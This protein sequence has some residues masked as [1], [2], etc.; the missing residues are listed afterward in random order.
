M[1]DVTVYN[2]NNIAGIQATPAAASAGLTDRFQ[3]GFGQKYLLEI[4][5]T[6]GAS[7][8]VTVD[9]PDAT[10]PGGFKTLNRDVDIVLAT[11]QKRG[12]VVDSARFRDSSGWVNLSIN[13]NT[14][15]TYTVW[16]PLA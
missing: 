8:T 3:T 6:S 1:A 5:N 10:N 14:G 16:G 13:A 15:V 7:R 4:D 9:D 12:F 11:N 2:P